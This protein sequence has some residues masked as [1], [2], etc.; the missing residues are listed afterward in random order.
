MKIYDITQELFTSVV[1][2]GD[3]SPTYERILQIKEGAPCNVTV[4]NMCAH[5]GTHVDA[6]YHFYENGK[7]IEEIDLNKLVGYCS[8]VSFK[9]QPSLEE[10]EQI[11]QNSEK[12][13]LVKGD[14]ILTLELAQLMNQYELDL[15]GI[16][17]QSVDPVDAPK[18]IHYELLK[19]DVVLLEGV[20][21]E[22]V[23]EG[24]YLLSAAPIKMGGCDGAPCR[25]LLMEI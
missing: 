19:Q 21:L 18:Q 11:L 24:K 4:F 9:C 22:Q 7:T 20:C 15:I 3:V 23:P 8:V 16:E 5:N 1:Y 14:I 25:A 10:M 2:P 6:P 12:R 13:L 17:G